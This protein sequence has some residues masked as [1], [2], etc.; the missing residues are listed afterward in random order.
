MIGTSLPELLFIRASVF[1]LHYFALILIGLLVLLL[2]TNHS[3]AKFTT[4]IQTLAILETAFYVL[5]FLP[6]QRRQS[7]TAHPP[8]LPVDERRKIFTKTIES[9][10][11]GDTYLTKWFNHA[12]L[13]EIKRENL[14]DFLAWAF[15][16]KEYWG[17][18][19]EEELDEYVVKTEEVLGRKLEKGRGKAIPIRL[20][21]DPVVM[22]H[23]PLLWYLTVAFVDTITFLRLQYY[24]FTFYKLP[25]TRFFTVFPFRP[26]TLACPRTS[27]SKKLSYWY[28][29]HTSRSRKPILLIHGIGIGLWPYVSLMKELN[30]ASATVADGEIGIIA[31]EIM[32][33]SFR[34]TGEIPDK[35]E[36]CSEILKILDNHGWKDFV[37]ASH[38]YGSVI[39]TQLIHHRHAKHRIR[40]ILLIDPVTFLLHL[41]DVAYNF[42]KRPPRRANERQ[43]YYFASTDMCVANTLGRHF[44][45]LENIL[46]KED[47]HSRN[48]TV[49][50]A[51]KDLISPTHAVAKYLLDEEPAYERFLSEDE[52]DGGTVLRGEED[53]RQRMWK[54][55]GI[56]VLWFEDCDHAHVLDRW[57]NYR[58]LVDVLRAY[59]AEE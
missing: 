9:V 21:T 11:D 23:R 40:S 18:E 42:T 30:K 46:W 48:V 45:W 57:R 12:P 31:I 26:I 19:D 14:K 52:V 38:S 4:F 33:I 54:G 37:L 6:Q 15:L 1:F 39:S 7:K 13:A 25:L 10:Q 59:C 17:T 22:L 24:G 53:W 56:D 16:S 28:K 44:F 41:P 20:T 55:E 51:A 50:L 43:L 35:E 8:T 49:A 29:P 2:V 5:V 3:H 47:L 27:P 34:I 36:M 32:P 58:K